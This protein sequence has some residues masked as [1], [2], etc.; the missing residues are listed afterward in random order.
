MQYSKQWLR[1]AQQLCGSFGPEDGVDPRYLGRTASRKTKHHKNG[2][3]CRQSIRILSTILVLF[4]YD[5]AR[6]SVTVVLCNKTQCAGKGY[7]LFKYCNA[8]AG[9]HGSALWVSLS[10]PMDS[11]VPFGNRI[12][13]SCKPRLAMHTDKLTEPGN[14]ILK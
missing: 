6:F 11:V 3:L 14:I 9:R 7:S 13:I 1:A 12:T 8:I 10:A 5:I 2:Q 4:Q